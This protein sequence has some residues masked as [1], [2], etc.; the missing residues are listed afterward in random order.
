MPALMRAADLVVTKAGPGAIAEALA[1]GVPLVLTGYLPG[2]ETANVRFV[3]ESGFGLYAPR[4]DELRASV[5]RLLA[6]DGQEAGVMAAAAAAIARP[7][8][9]L[10]I[11]RECI[12]LAHRY[13]AE[14]M[15]PRLGPG[16]TGGRVVGR[17]V[18]VGKR[19]AGGG[20]G[21]AA[22]RGSAGA[23][24]AAGKAGGAAGV[25]DV[26]EVPAA[27]DAPEV[28]EAP[29]GAATDLPAGASPRAVGGRAPRAGDGASGRGASTDQDQAPG[30]TA[31]SANGTGRR[32]RRL[33]LRRV[34]ERSEP[35]E[36]RNL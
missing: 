34:L 17:R 29:T 16:A 5:T 1:T 31:D 11:A 6:A 35:P 13:A 21:A 33:R 25:R 12:T 23:R 27:P 2:Q 32:W 28:L 4:P 26:P 7:Y 3:T 22:K 36:S 30:G 18:A 10:D 15:R 19:G 24:S 9:S 14:R 8:A 20:R